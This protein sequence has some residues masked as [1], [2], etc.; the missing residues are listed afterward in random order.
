MHSPLEQFE[1]K[2]IIPI[3]IGGL[4][5]SITNS[6]LFMIMA[7]IT[8]VITAVLGVRRTHLIPSRMQSLNEMMFELVDG[9][10]I[11]SAGPEAKKYVPFMFTLFV[12]ILTCNLLGMLP[13]AFTVTSHIAVTFT[14]ALVIFLGITMIGFI[15]HGLHFL[16][17][18]LPQGTPLIMAP[19]MIVIEI[20]TYFIRPIS[21]SIRLAANMTAGHLVMKVIASLTLMAGMLGVLPFALLLALVGFEFFVAGLQAYIFTILSCVYLSDAIKLH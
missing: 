15:R 18:F 6:S 7:L 1:I 13:Y 11:G 3:N 14:I 9:M 16:K 2:R 20:F 21:L 8:I 10:V 17:L 19:L 5:V 4:D 12:F